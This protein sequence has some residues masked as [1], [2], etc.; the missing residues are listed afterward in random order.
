MNGRFFAQ[1]RIEAYLSEGKP[2]FKRS[3]AGL[4]DDEDPTAEDAER[5]KAFGDWLEKG[6][7]DD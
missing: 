4:D 7:E 1:R 2:K 6:G 3:G 5:E